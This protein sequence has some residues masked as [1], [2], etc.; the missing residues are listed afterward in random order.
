[1]I[2]FSLF[3]LFRRQA[4]DIFRCLHIVN[5]TMRNNLLNLNQNINL[6]FPENAFENVVWIMSDGLI[7]M[8]IKD[9]LVILRF[10]WNQKQ[11]KQKSVNLADHTHTPGI[12][13]S[14]S[15]INNS[16]FIQS[17]YFCFA[18]NFID[19]KKTSLSLHE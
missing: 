3:R 9:V 4:I 12:I 6:F 5:R 17:R 11:N 13:N 16:S 10:C 18:T 2:L 14:Y 15:Y 8:Q 1:M 7:I 19:A